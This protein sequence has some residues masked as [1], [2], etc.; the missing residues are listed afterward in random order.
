[1]TPMRPYGS[2]VT[3]LGLALLLLGLL[4]AAPSHAAERD[5]YK[6]NGVV[7]SISVRTPEQ[8][9]AF[10]LARG[11][12]EAAVRELETKC[13]VTIG[14][15]NGRDDVL[16][17]E[18]AKWHFITESGE[19]VARISRPEWN[20]RWAQL[21]IPLASRATFGWTQLP[22]SRDLL[23]GEGVGGNVAIVAPS[24]AFSVEAIF[25]TGANRHGPKVK[26]KADKLKCGPL[27][28][29]KK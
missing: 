12:P 4:A 9:R 3:R 11:F 24:E 2:S 5:V 14:V 25:D 16:W 29:G 18:P 7:F 17:L 21:D 28:E 19:K 27:S 26:I 23:A 1:M 10:Y 15:Q 13:L 6:S 8:I 20:T 22:E